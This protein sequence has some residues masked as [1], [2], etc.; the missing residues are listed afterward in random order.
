MSSKPPELSTGWSGCVLHACS[1]SRMWQSGS[2]TL[3]TL[4]VLQGVKELC[5]LLRDQALPL[6]SLKL[7]LEQPEPELH[8]LAQEQVTAIMQI[9]PGEHT[10]SCGWASFQDSLLS[11]FFF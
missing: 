8:A 3:L 1:Q 2:T 5:L 6:L 9:G 4:C 11:L 7:L 10:R